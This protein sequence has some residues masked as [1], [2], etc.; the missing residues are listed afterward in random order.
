M[1][2]YTIAITR[3]HSRN[4]NKAGGKL[5]NVVCIEP[6]D[7]SDA[8]AQMPEQ[9]KLFYWRSAYLSDSEHNELLTAHSD[10]E[11]ELEMT[12]FSQ[13]DIKKLEK[14]GD[15]PEKLGGVIGRNS[16]KIRDK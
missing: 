6:G 10:P 12:G 13:G 8:W 5:G 11:K 15:L 14:R 16:F 3:G 9:R 4:P 1:A 7:H 2:K